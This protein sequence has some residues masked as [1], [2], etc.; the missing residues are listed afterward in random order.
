LRTKSSPAVSDP[1]LR[2][3]Q[4]YLNLCSKDDDCLTE[5]SLLGELSL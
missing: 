2:L 5:F 1:A 4:K 3:Y